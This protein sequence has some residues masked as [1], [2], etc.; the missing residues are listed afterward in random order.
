MK[1]RETLG[2][3]SAIP[4]CPSDTPMMIVTL[5]MSVDLRRRIAN[6]PSLDGPTSPG[7]RH[8]GRRRGP[9]QHL[10]PDDPAGEERLRTKPQA[11]HRRPSAS[12]APSQREPDGGASRGGR[13]GAN[14]RAAGLPRDL[15]ATNRPALCRWRLMGRLGPKGLSRESRRRPP[16]RPRRR[17]CRAQSPA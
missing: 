10:W 6:A 12:V 5:F 17:S 7:G 4:S 15:P 1:A 16:P 14:R 8:G 9:R 2:K 3:P 11:A 13:P